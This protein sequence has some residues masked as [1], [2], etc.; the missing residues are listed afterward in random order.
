MAEAAAGGFYVGLGPLEMGG[1]VVDQGIQAG[2]AGAGGQEDC[3]Q[4][5]RLGL[6]RSREHMQ[7]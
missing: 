5:E 7:L 6:E 4:E 3:Q 2:Q 1:T